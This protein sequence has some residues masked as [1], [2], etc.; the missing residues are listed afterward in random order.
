[1]FFK[2]FFSAASGT[3]IRANQQCH[4]INAEDTAEWQRLLLC[5]RDGFSRKN[6]RIARPGGTGIR[7]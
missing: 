6:I 7:N 5:H 3:L 2:S 4:R 1:M